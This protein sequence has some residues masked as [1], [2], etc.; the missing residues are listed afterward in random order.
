M[1]RIAI[2]HGFAETVEDNPEEELRWLAPERVVITDET[3]VSGGIYCK[4]G[5]FHK[6]QKV[7]STRTSL[8][9]ESR[10]RSVLKMGG[11]YGEHITLVAGHNMAGEPTM[12]VWVFSAERDIRNRAE[13]EEAAVTTPGSTTLPPIN[14]Q[15]WDKV[16]VTCSKN[17]GIV[18]ESLT[19]VFP[20]LANESGKRVLRFTDWH[21]S[22]LSVPFLKELRE[23]GVVLAWWLP[24]CTSLMQSPDTTLV[25]PSRMYVMR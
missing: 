17:I 11:E 16:L 6:D 22:G 1:K 9:P 10:R 23:N 25:G 2:E 19:L 4:V 14:A 8:S 21:A 18:Q 20:D 7:E 15:R 24:M 13:I 12:P 3:C 5:A